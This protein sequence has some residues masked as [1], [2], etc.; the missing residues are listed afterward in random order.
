MSSCPCRSEKEYTE[1]C[2]PFHLGHVMPRTA[3]QLM[4]AR[5]SAFVV[6]L[7]DY[8]VDTTHPDHRDKGLRTSVVHWMAQTSWDGLDVI[9]TEGG[10]E[11]DNLG[12][13]EF[14]ANYTFNEKPRKHHELSKFRLV[15]DRWM[16]CDSEV[17]ED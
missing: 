4:R 14:V 12:K 5:Y 13:V 3:E 7:P 16:F 17:Y 9:K 10:S 11:S 2:A 15:E 6:T 1:C 8:I